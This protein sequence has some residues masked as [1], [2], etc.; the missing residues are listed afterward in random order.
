MKA[1]L[2]RVSEASVSLDGEVLSAIGPGLVVLVGSPIL[3]WV[4]P[5]R[6]SALT[7]LRLA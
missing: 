6:A 2:Q 4:V 5:R 3:R 7:R 1:L